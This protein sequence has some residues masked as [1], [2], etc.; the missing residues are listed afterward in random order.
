VHIPVLLNEVIKYLNP[1]PGENFIDC[2]VGAGGHSLAIFKKNKPGKLLAIDC[3]NES[4]E[5]FKSKIR[6]SEF[7]FLRRLTLANDNFRNLKKIVEK[8]KFHPV[9]GIL[10]D[11]GLSSWHIE[12]SKKGFTFRK[13]EPLGM[14]FDNRSPS[15]AEII[16]NFSEKSLE[17][18]FSKYGEERYSR[19][20]AR[21]II[22]KRKNKPIETTFQLRNIVGEVIPFSKTRRGNID[23]VLARIFQSLRIAVN[24]ELENLKQG[25]KQSLE[26]LEPGGRLIIISF[27]SL[28]DR[29]VK[30]FFRD[31]KIKNSLKILT[32]KPIIA[33][34]EEV[35]NNPR[36]RSAKL[37][38]AVKV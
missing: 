29:I 20:I 31:E 27:H 36:S 6:N 10:L 14:N 12:E 25:L 22:E 33:D 21:R 34:E 26:I 30:N 1:K 7:S 32:K 18:I 11:L 23:R 9:N 4:L 8:Y 16:N 17:E 13:D 28:E 15:A 38:A 3:D 37:R 35:K 24:D 5:L 2:T 19:R